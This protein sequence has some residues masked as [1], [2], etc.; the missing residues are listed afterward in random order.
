MDPASRRIHITSVMPLR[1]PAPGSIPAMLSALQEWSSR[2]EDALADLEARKNHIISMAEER[3]EMKRLREAEVKVEMER[4]EKAI[5][6]AKAAG[7]G[8]SGG[9]G[10]EE[11]DVMDV[12]EDSFGVGKRSGLRSSKKVPF[13]LSGTGKRAG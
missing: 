12:D 10:Q 8:A 13:G 4:R 2:C 11:D 5:A 1:D 6:S 9:A 3:G 7:A